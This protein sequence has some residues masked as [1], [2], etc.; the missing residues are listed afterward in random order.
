MRRIGLAAA[1]GLI[2]LIAVRA[3]VPAGDGLRA[4][5]FANTAWSGDPVLSVADTTLSPM[6]LA[7]R[8]RLSPEQFSIQ[9]TGFLI[10]PETGSYAFALSSDD[11][12][13]LFVDGSPIVDNSGIHSLQSKSASV[14]LDGG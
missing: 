4:Q 11:G 2:V 9:W 5:L 3:A 10:A 7:A 1:L 6:R 12:S 13:E 14:S 8:A